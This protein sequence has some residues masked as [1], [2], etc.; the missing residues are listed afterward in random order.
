MAMPTCYLQKVQELKEEG[1]VRPL[2]QAQA[3][4]TPLPDLLACLKWMYH[5]WC[6]CSGH[7]HSGSGEWWPAPGL[8]T[9]WP[10]ASA[11]LWEELA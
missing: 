8:C 4:S 2:P 7:S 10:G 3:N 11:D 6:S 5:P 9:P 1:A